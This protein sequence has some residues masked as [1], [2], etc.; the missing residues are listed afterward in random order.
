MDPLLF[1]NLGNCNFFLG[2]SST[3]VPQAATASH[4]QFLYIH[5]KV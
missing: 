1:V 3:P 5:Y 2:P 4:F